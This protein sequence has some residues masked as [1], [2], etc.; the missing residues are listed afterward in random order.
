MSVKK[1]AA[2]HGDCRVWWF[3]FGYDHVHPLTGESLR[4]CYVEVTGDSEETRIRMMEVFGN[5][6]AFQYP[7][8]D[9]AVT[10]HNLRRVP[11]FDRVS[12]T[13]GTL[14]P[15]THHERAAHYWPLQAIILDE[16]Y[17]NGS[18]EAA[19]RLVPHIPTIT[20]IVTFVRQHKIPPTATIQHSNV[21]NCLIVAW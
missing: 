10:K 7:E 9:L 4:D 17:E 12:Y 11:W 16:E 20:E 15:P 8:G 19:H 2:K 3:T 14:L 18:V 21:S 13:F 5:K 6:W 1:P